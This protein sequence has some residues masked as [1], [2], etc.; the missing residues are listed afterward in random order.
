MKMNII[1]IGGIN[2]NYSV[3]GKGQ[4]LMLIHG[5]GES[6]YTWRRN[7]G[8][9]AE[10]FAVYALDLKGFGD[11]GKP[12]DG[13]YSVPAMAELVLQFMHALK[14]E[15]TVLVCRSFAGKIGI[16]AILS[17]PSLFNGLVLLGSAIGDF[18]I[19]P[20][21]LAMADEGVGEKMML[22]QNE[23]NMRP[24]VESLHDKS[25][26]VTIEDIRE[27]LRPSKG[28]AA[29]IAY[30]TYF[31]DFIADRGLLLEE[32]EKLTVPTLIIWGKNDAFISPRHGELIKKRIKNAKLGIVDKGGHNVHEDQ[33]E[34]VNRL[35]IEFF[36]KGKD[37][38]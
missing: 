35:I 33:P 27:F 26:T 31:R 21:F 7:I 11:S 37:L 1:D 4:P 9:L 24:V 25:Y 16:R 13:D 15:K 29:I 28:T 10:R 8:G 22:A 36:G 3:K 2:I 38:S 12:L 18:A 23:T 6:I 19:W 5:H 30:L 20:A 34:K 32:L 14:I 17:D